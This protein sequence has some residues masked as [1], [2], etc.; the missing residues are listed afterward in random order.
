MQ[1]EKL[2]IGEGPLKIALSASIVEKIKEMQETYEFHTESGGILVGYYACSID[3]IN[4]SE[5]SSPQRDD[6]R[7]RL[8]FL[9]RPRG[10]QEFIDNLW[11]TSGHRKAYIG[12]WHTHNQMMPEPSQTDKR[13]W[14]RI[15]QKDHQFDGMYFMI[16]GIKEVGI[17][18]VFK[19]KVIKVGSFYPERI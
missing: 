10:H 16:I 2:I 12:E 3:S 15:S 9:R 7:G 19:N 18:S 13:E 6:I 5:M 11:E 8:S 17:W 14:K 1:D 4:I